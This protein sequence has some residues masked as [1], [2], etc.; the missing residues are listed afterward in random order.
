MTPAEEYAPLSLSPWRRS[1]GLVL[2]ALRRFRD[3]LAGRLLVVVG[4]MTLLI[5]VAV[6]APVMGNFHHSWIRERI[7]LAQTAVLSLDVSPTFTITEALRQELLD[8]ADVLRIALKR[9]EDRELILDAG[10]TT[11]VLSDLDYTRRTSW[12]THSMQ[13]LDCIFAPEGRTLRVL[14][15]PRFES[16]EFIEIVLREAPLKQALETFALNFAFFSSLILIM[17]GGAVYAVL[18]LMFVRPLARLTE[19]IEGFRARPEDASLEFHTSSRADEIGLIERAAADMADQIR[20]N[21]RQRE[22]L[23]SL[24]GAVARIG[25]DLRNILS[26]ARMVTERVA[27]SDDPR[28][29]QSAPRL[30]RAIDRAAALAET[31]LRFGRADEPPPV[32]SVRSVQG[33]VLEAIADAVVGIPDVPTRSEVEPDLKMRVDPEHAHRIILN[34]VRNAAQ[35][36]SGT[37]RAGDGVFVHAYRIGGAINIEVIDHGAGVPARVRATLFEPFVTSDAK[38]GGAGLGLA[39]ARELARGMG[40]DVTLIHSNSEGAAFRA[41][42]LAA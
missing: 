18:D 31:T 24:G 16:G 29:R 21:L 3:S 7:N 34:L 40:G 42:L 9:Y 10:E 22:R 37:P 35:A 38:G 8:N 32:M 11:G 15:R 30:E 17:L 33:V 2:R 28:V 23:A 12:L 6:F 13:A 41:T 1:L 5:Q 36:M 27:Q 20:L 4:G 19:S 26:T 25:H 39:I 14:A